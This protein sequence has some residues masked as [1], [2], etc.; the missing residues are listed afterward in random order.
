[1]VYKGSI[2][3][4]L[5]RIRASEKTDSESETRLSWSKE[6]E[7]HQSTQ[8]FTNSLLTKKINFSSLGKPATKK[9]NF[10]WSSKKRWPLC[11]RGGCKALVTGPLKK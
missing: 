9:N 3:L 6:I 2:W 7:V 1:M 10:F 5:N 4:G 11:S 8:L